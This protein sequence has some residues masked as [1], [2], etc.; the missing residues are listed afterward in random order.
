M[1]KYEEKDM[2]PVRG[3]QPG[4]FTEGIQRVRNPPLE[5]PAKLPA[6]E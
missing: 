3:L 5:L 2:V 4:E 6:T 1:E